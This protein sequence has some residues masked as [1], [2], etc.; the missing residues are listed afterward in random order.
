[1]EMLIFLSV[2]QFDAVAA[3]VLQY[4]LSIDFC[5]TL[6][7]CGFLRQLINCMCKLLPQTRILRLLQRCKSRILYWPTIWA[8]QKFGNQ[9]NAAESNARFFRIIEPFRPYIIGIIFQLFPC[10][11]S[12]SFS[13][14]AKSDPYLGYSASWVAILSNL[15]LQ[16]CNILLG[17]NLLCFGLNRCTRT[18]ALHWLVFEDCYSL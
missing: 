10:S 16:I 12:R 4:L 2:P 8:W 5:F 13:C 7:V 6:C 14:I 17:R 3:C 9:H 11:V 15:S 18:H 1:M